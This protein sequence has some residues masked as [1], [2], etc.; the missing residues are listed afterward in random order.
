MA[1][2]GISQHVLSRWLPLLTLFTVVVLFVYVTVQQVYRTIGNDPQIDTA[3]VIVE[4]L[5]NGA[6]PEEL[7]G[8]EQVDLRINPSVFITIVDREGTVVD[9]N[10]ILDGKHPVPP[11]GAIQAAEFVQNKVTWEPATTI[12]LATVIQTSTA[13]H[14]YVIVGRSLFETEHRIA[15]FGWF[16][17]T[18]WLIGAA[19]LLV[20]VLITE[21]IKTTKPE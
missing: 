16:A 20:V 5:T 19:A 18:V 11:I 15:L 9:S 14:Q 4:K 2:S 21:K 8:A 6:K 7:V 1:T 10:A 17:L 3:K 13:T 12:R